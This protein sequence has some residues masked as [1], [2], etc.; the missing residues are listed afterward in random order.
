MNIGGSFSLNG[1]FETETL[2][3]VLA[4]ISVR[5]AYSWEDV[6]YNTDLMI[7]Y[8]Y[9]AAAGFPGFD[10]I[11][12]PEDCF[13]TFVPGYFNKF[14]LTLESE[15]IK[16][17]QAKCKELSV[18]GVFSPWLKAKSGDTRY[19]ENTAILINDQG[20]IVHQYVKN[21]P[22]LPAE[23][24]LPGTEVPVTNGPKGSK[25]ATIICADG[26][27]PEI[28]REAA[29]NGANIIIRV[30]DYMAPWD[31]AW[32]LTNRSNAYSNQVY[33]VA[34][35]QCNVDESYDYFGDSM[36][37]NPDGT[38]LSRAPKRAPGMIKVNLYPGIIEQM[39]KQ[40]CHGNY[41][42]QYNHRG[43]ACPEVGIE[44]VGLDLSTY[45]AYKSVK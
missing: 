19:L 11:V 40:E 22:W 28:W 27:Y 30:A 34:C 23:N 31:Q 7:E 13:Q 14:G 20:D 18:W 8:M 33:V 3:C 9:K 36:V 21:N 35:N 24:T 10:L 6:N 41:T 17:L 25:I 12:F 4:Q 5:S 2:S 16:K 43:A 26:D 42:W 29:V 37:V 44:G 45:N 38:I 39:K 32:E 15:Q 1:K